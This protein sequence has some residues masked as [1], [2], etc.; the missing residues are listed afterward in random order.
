M[1]IRYPRLHNAVRRAIHR[2]RRNGVARHHSGRLVGKVMNTRLASTNDSSPSTVLWF[3]RRDP[4][5][6]PPKASDAM[7]DTLRGCWLR[8]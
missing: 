7:G 6:L 5:K 8:V 1:L 2:A 4:A 3:P